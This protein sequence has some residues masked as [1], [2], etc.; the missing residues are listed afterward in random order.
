MQVDYELDL[1][2]EQWL[3]RL[4]DAEKGRN[5]W[6]MFLEEDM[7][8]LIDRYEKADAALHKLAGHSAV[9]TEVLL[10][11]RP[12]VSDVR[13]VSTMVQE[14]VYEWWTEK[15]NQ[16]GEQLLRRL[17]A[18][19]TPLMRTTIRRFAASPSSALVGSRFCRPRPVLRALRRSTRSATLSR[20]IIVGVASTSGVS[21]PP[22]TRMV[23]LP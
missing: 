13:G 11:E 7:E 1:Q 10:L 3:K 9:R 5:N 20:Q 19:P 4:N 22:S 8:V 6:A 2:D 12:A 23:P 17:R 14:Q 21:S 18:P 16:R 15:R